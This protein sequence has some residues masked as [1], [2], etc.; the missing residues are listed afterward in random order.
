MIEADGNQSLAVKCQSHEKAPAKLGDLG[1]RNVDLS[2]RHA[3]PIMPQQGTPPLS[4]S[5]LRIG[6]GR[7][8]PTAWRP[9]R[10][11]PPT[12]G[13]KAGNKE[14]R[15]IPEPNRLRKKAEN[16]LLTRAAQNRAHVFAA[17]YRAATVRGR[18][19][20]AVPTIPF[21]Q[22]AKRCLNDAECQSG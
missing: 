12:P 7:K 16:R 6:R 21:R 1:L 3:Y 22:P 9:S 4:F 11:N 20:G 5:C 17:T 19:Q 10:P 14:A 15:E 8:P 18:S 13:L 2:Q